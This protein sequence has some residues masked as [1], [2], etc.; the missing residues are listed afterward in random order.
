[1]AALLLL[2]FCIEEVVRMEDMRILGNMIEKLAA[3]QHVTSDDLGALLQCTSEQ[4]ARL[5]KGRLFL[6][7]DQL[8]AVSEHLK[9]S[10]DTLLA[11][12]RENYCHT[13]VH[14]MGEF[15]DEANREEILDI[16]DDYLDLCHT[17][18]V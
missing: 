15:S 4:V 2:R 11:G 6:T 14:C 7:F 3:E 5:F 12:D 1:M 17:A 10:I 16:I 18:Q 8:T 9:V 13:V